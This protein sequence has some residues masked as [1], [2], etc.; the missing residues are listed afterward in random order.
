MRD[1]G[2]GRRDTRRLAEL[3]FVAPRITLARVL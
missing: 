2:I 1:I 3:L